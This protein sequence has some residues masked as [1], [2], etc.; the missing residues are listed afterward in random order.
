MYVNKQAPKE[1]FHDNIWVTYSDFFKSALFCL[2]SLKL[3]I[4]SHSIDFKI[5]QQENDPQCEHTASMH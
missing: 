5:H 4:M 3:L 2:N 1:K